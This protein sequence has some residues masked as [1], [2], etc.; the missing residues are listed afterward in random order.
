MPAVPVTG[1]NMGF[2]DK[3]GGGAAANSLEAEARASYARY[4]ASHPGTTV[5]YDQYA[6]AYA[7][8]LVRRYNAQFDTGLMYKGYLARNPGTPVT[9][10]QYV[11]V[12]THDPVVRNREID[13]FTGK[14]A[15]EER[16]AAASETAEWDPAVKKAI[17]GY[18]HDIIQQ[19]AAGDLEGV[20]RKL[21]LLK[22]LLEGEIEKHN[23]LLYED[24]LAA[25]AKLLKTIADFGGGLAG[26]EAVRL[27]AAAVRAY[28]AAATVPKPPVYTPL[29]PKP[30]DGWRYRTPADAANPE[31]GT[32]FGGREIIPVSVKGY[33]IM[34]PPGWRFL[35]PAEEAAAFASKK[36]GDVFAGHRIIRVSSPGAQL[37]KA[38]VPIVNIPA[39]PITILPAANPGFQWVFRGGA[40]VQERLPPVTEFLVPGTTGLQQGTPAGWRVLQRNEVAPVGVAR[41]YAGVTIVPI[42]GAVYVEPIPATPANTV[43]P[44][45]AGPAIRPNI[46]PPGWL[47]PAQAEAFA[48]NN[49]PWGGAGMTHVEQMEA[50][51][52]LF[53]R[54]YRFHPAERLYEPI[55]ILRPVG[56]LAPPSGLSALALLTGGGGGS[57]GKD[58]VAGPAG[59]GGQLGYGALTGAGDNALLAYDS[60]TLPAGALDA[61]ETIITAARAGTL[62]NLFVRRA[63]AAV[64]TVRHI[65]RVNGVDTL[66]T[67][68]IAGVATTGSDTVNT[69]AVVQGDLISV[70]VVGAGGAVDAITRADLEI[71]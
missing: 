37:V 32:T 67:A 29:V 10:K 22:A 41:K 45:P 9:Y 20:A 57:P 49:L 18:T 43:L 12:I 66:I 46:P 19:Q 28:V 17:D 63:A 38:P 14:T 44:I 71:A 15:Q 60:G 30:P 2:Y 26:T 13:A 39:R 53:P 64:G 56:A 11:Y 48:R 35:T 52:E 50:I 16:E 42:E 69:S 59:A 70:H 34:A 23:W 5:T 33:P 51:R 6:A 55:Q 58:G 27:F 61:T 31:V 21:A 47:T 25:M 36:V 1:Y 62:R 68:A 40:W 24:K 7:D 3:R 8:E 54:L 4:V 65:V